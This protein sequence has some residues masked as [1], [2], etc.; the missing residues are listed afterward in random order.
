MSTITVDR[1][2]LEQALEEL[3]N[4]TSEYGHRCNRCD[5]EVDEGGRVAAAL[6][7]ALEQP[8]KTI[9]PAEPSAA[10]VMRDLLLRLEDYVE[11]L[12]GTSVENEK[13]VDDY[14]AWRA[15]VAGENK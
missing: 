11:A 1:A 14:R 12:D 8:V 7:V 6:R 4:C 15:L 2:V 5:S 10:L 13:L 9:C 3:E